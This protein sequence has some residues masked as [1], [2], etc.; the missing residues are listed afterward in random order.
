[1]YI[2][3]IVNVTGSYYRPAK[4][5]QETFGITSD[6]NYYGYYQSRIILSAK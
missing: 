3:F 5:K 6:L 1:M 4:V 2:N